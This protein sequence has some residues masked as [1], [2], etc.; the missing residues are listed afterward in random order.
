MYDS[1]GS[2]KTMA[3]KHKHTTV[4][5]QG[6]MA[7]AGVNAQSTIKYLKQLRTA[8]V[9]IRAIKTVISLRI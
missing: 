6:R 8:R 2:H 7:L 3:V 5:R 4:T 9:S 1:I